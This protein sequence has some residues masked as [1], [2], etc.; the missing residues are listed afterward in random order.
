MVGWVVF[1]EVLEDAVEEE[2]D[3]GDGFKEAGF[4][5]ELKG[6]LLHFVLHGGLQDVVEIG[7]E[8][9]SLLEQVENDPMS[10]Q[11][12]KDL[13][14][15]LQLVGLLLLILF[16]EDAFGLGEGFKGLEEIVVVLQVLLQVLIKDG[17]RLVREVLVLQLF[18]EL[19]ELHKR[20][21]LVATRNYL[22]LRQLPA[23]RP[24]LRTALVHQGDRAVLQLRV[25]REKKTEDKTLEN[26]LFDD[27]IEV[28][29]L[30][31]VGLVDEDTLLLDLLSDL[32]QVHRQQLLE[33]RNEVRNAL[34]LGL[35]RVRLERII[36]R[37]KLTLE[38]SNRIVNE[39]LLRIRHQIIENTAN[40][41]LRLDL[42]PVLLL[43]VLYNER[44]RRKLHKD[45]L[46]RHDLTE[47]R[48]LC[49]LPIEFHYLSHLRLVALHLHFLLLF[50]RLFFLLHDH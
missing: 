40:L 36:P 41:D 24:L 32:G 49:K 45:L 15:G 50:R 39:V 44:L 35:L 16:L 19:R 1:A 31:T 11:V 5:G 48:I 37:H 7:E 4:L 26:R 21:L 47:K 10:L 46:Q 27:L 42:K 22:H 29:I 33:V 13:L 28:L 8:D 2:K 14:T 43:L 25:R 34:L 18:Q 20:C 6:L 9:E 38:V 3:L 12:F 17:P 23:E 30:R